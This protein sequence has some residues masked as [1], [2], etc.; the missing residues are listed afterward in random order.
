MKSRF[1]GPGRRAGEFL[2]L[3]TAAVLIAPAGHAAAAV[4]PPEIEALVDQARSVPPELGAE[5][6]IRLAESD[7]VADRAWKIGLLEE[8]F[9]QGTL[10]QLRWKRVAV[11][12]GRDPAAAFLNKAYA[13]NLDANSLQC[14]V[15]LAMLPLDRKKAKELFLDVPPPRLESLSCSDRLVHDVSLYY[16]TLAQVANTAFSPKEIAEDEPLRM[17]QRFLVGVTSPV[18]IGPVAQMLSN[19]KLKSEQREALMMSFAGMLKDI[20]GDPRSFAAVTANRSETGPQ[21]L[22]LAASARDQQIGTYPLL[23]AYRAFLVRNM[24]GVKCEEPALPAGTFGFAQSQ[25]PPE[26][27]VTFFNANLRAQNYPPG[28]E[29]KAISADEVQPDKVE[30]VRTDPSICSSSSCQQLSANYRTL[31]VNSAGFPVRPEEKENAEWRTRLKAFL[32]SIAAWKDED[33]NPSAYFRQ[34]CA[35][36]SNLLN[37]VPKGSDRDDLMR[38]MLAFLTRNPYQR[39]HRVEWFLPVYALIGRIFIDP[40]GLSQAMKELRGSDDPVIAL[41]ANLEQVA[42]RPPEAI[43]SLL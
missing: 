1:P 35:L 8:A 5:A 34:K 39:E 38:S 37:L 32:A 26:D 16:V 3:L 28:A 4:H 29:I 41:F 11:E 20:A 33:S 24:S 18:Q 40:V 30:P 43:V 2:W 12:F 23:E 17:V 31:I 9:Q 21:I 6:L 14:R 13:Q 42:P 7:K 25:P 27:A 19:L 36:Y 15:V 22:K 10:A